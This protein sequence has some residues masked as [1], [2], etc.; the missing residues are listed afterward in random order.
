MAIEHSS[1]PIAAVQFHP[2]SILTARGEAGLAL[3]RRAVAA[4]TEGR[5]V[6]A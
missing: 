2:E 1:L 3:V 6:A 5:K 4:L